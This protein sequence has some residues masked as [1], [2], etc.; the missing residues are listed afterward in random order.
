MHIRREWERDREG[1]GEREREGGREGMEGGEDQRTFTHNQHAHNQQ[2]MYSIHS[3]LFFHRL[4]V[5]SSSS[6]TLK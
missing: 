3:I 6:F 2:I 4:E 5:V 1:D